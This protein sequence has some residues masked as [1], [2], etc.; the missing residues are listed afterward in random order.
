MAWESVVAD[1]SVVVI[2]LSR[3]LD[4]AHATMV[5]SIW[6]GTCIVGSVY[7]FCGWGLRDTEPPGAAAW[8]SI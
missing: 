3:Q 7:G 1:V 4:E 8:V 6:F 2:I 5:I